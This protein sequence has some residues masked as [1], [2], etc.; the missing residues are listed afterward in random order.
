[1]RSSWLLIF[2]LYSLNSIAQ[3]PDFKFGPRF[4]SGVSDFTKMPDLHS[5][6]VPAFELGLVADRQLKNYFG[7]EIKPMFSVYGS[8]TKGM[9]LWGYD[10]LGNPIYYTFSDIYQVAVVEFPFLAKFGFQVNH[11]YF[12]TFFGPSVCA[13]MFGMHSRRYD[14][15]NYNFDHG[16]TG[17]HIK[18]L[19]D[20]CYAGIFGIGVERKMKTGT[21]G[22]DITAH[23]QITPMGKIEGSKFYV[24]SCTVGISWMQ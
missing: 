9:E 1:M 18:E 8:R 7:L 10:K 5:Q 23:K 6:Q 17:I 12:N 11:L 4:G 15:E 24:Q 13:D 19:Y 16:F 3:A 14:D 20:G 22:F 2:F 21:L